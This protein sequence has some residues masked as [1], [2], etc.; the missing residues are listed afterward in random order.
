[1]GRPLKIV[2]ALAALALVAC[3]AAG[4][5]PEDP[6][7]GKQPCDH[8]AML[9][10]EPRFAAQALTKDGAHLYFDDVGCLSGWMREHPG[11]ATALWVDRDGAWVPAGEARY[12]SGERTPMGYGFVASATGALDWTAVQQ[13]LAARAQAEVHDAQ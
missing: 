9:V 11:A 4:P 13:R 3:K 1:M 10:D 7:W 8:C 5:K 6:V 12:V 2:L